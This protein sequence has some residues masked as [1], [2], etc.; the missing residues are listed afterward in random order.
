MVDG[1]FIPLNGKI[2]CSIG[3][4]VAGCSPSSRETLVLSV[5]QITYLEND[6]QYA[7]KRNSE[8]RSPN[9]LHILSVCLYP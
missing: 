4:S 6:G 7:Y 2:S 5:S 9:I 1:S 8:V 3:N